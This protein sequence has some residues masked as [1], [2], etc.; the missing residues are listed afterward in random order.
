E[1][2][3]V[4]VG[5][6]VERALPDDLAR[7][8]GMAEPTRAAALAKL[9]QVG[10]EIGYPDRWRDFGAYAPARDRYLENVWAAAELTAR[11]ELDWIGRPADR[12]AL[13]C[14]RIHPH[15]REATRH[16]RPHTMIF[17]A[18][19]LQPPFFVPGAGAGNF[20]QIGWVMGHELTHGF[21]QG[22]R[23][24]DG[25]GSVR[26]WWSAAAARAFDERAQCMVD[27]YGRLEVA[28]GVRQDAKTTLADDIADNAGLR[29]SFAAWKAARAGQAPLPQ[30]A[31][32]DEDQQFFVSSGQGCAVA[33]PEFL[34]A[35]V[36]TNFHS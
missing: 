16:P 20:A 17:T 35:Q 21:D 15:Q 23:K 5:G 26:D 32:L 3:A 30:V 28:P 13:P 9:G 31:G 24:Y 25:T 18:A 8:P 27:E 12:S 33:S 10:N 14:R 7:L 1:R 29:L 4:E 34:Q 6:A 19:I 11:R 22:G 2:E 36:K